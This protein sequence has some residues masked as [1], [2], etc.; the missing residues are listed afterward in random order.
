MAGSRS[1]LAD[2]VG[3]TASPGRRDRGRPQSC[4]PGGRRCPADDVAS[5]RIIY[6]TVAAGAAPLVLLS[7]AIPAPA[8]E[9]LLLLLLLLLLEVLV[10]VVV[11]VVLLLL[12]L[13]EVVLGLVVLLLLVLVVLLLVAAVGHRRVP[14]TGRRGYGRTNA[15][16]EWIHFGSG[17]SVTPPIKER[18]QNNWS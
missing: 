8:V 9:L 14:D 16:H 17:G 15:V 11:V 4:R 1:E 10:L 18:H 3:L 6:C 7:G 13:L 2:A 5:P 12:L